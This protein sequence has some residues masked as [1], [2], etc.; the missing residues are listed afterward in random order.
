MSQILICQTVEQTVVEDSFGYNQ[1][2]GRI[3]VFE[4]RF[5]VVTLSSLNGLNSSP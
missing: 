3:H 5:L 1:F 2:N 4:K